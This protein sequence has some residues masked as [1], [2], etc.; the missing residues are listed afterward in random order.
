MY[1]GGPDDPEAYRGREA[2]I[3]G[4][5]DTR[6]EPGEWTFDWE[7]VSETPALVIVKGRTAVMIARYESLKSLGNSRSAAGLTAGRAAGPAFSR[8]L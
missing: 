5:L 8:L 6:D 3:D 4:W 7:I 2:I 1:E